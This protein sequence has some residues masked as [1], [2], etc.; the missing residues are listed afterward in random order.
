MLPERYNIN[1][2]K[3]SWHTPGVGNEQYFFPKAIK[4]VNRF[5]Q[6]A[7]AQQWK[8]QARTLGFNL[9]ILV[10]W[11]WHIIPEK[12]TFIKLTALSSSLK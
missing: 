9:I 12:P 11:D 1:P 4:M 5:Q 3:W 6:M 8:A 2:Q 7:S 10:T